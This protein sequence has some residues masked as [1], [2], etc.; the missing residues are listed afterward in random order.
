VVVRDEPVAVDL[1]TAERRANPETAPVPILQR[2]A[3][4]IETVRECHVTVQGDREAVNLITERTP[5]CC[6]DLL[7]YMLQRQF[8]SGP[9]VDP[10]LT[11]SA[12]MWLPESPCPM[13]G[14]KPVILPGSCFTPSST[15]WPAS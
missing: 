14:G 5:E 9:A 4:P 15:P 2:A 8:G 13:G 12:T 6:E 7:G 1:P 3:E 11:V 10:E